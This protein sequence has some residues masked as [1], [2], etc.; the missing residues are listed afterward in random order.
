MRLLLDEHYPARLAE[1]LRALGCDAVAVQERP[2]L[3]GRADAELLRRMRAE[4][5]VIVTEDRGDFGRLL[6]RRHDEL[7]D[8][9]GLVLVVPG[10]FPRTPAGLEALAEAL[11][12]LAAAAPTDAA[13]PGWVGWLSPRPPAP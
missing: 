9:A 1:R 6:K 2:D 5:R 3:R 13:V 10:R 4:G 8:H 12:A 11:H 7:G